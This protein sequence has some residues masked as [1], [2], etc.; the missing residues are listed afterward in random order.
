VGEQHGN[1][2]LSEP[3]L[4]ITVGEKDGQHQEDEDRIRKELTKLTKA[5]R[6]DSK[7]VSSC[8]EIKSL[9]P[10]RLL[11]ER[12]EA[13]LIECMRNVIGYR[14]DSVGRLLM[15][16]AAQ[17]EA[18]GNLLQHLTCTPRLVMS[19]LSFQ[20]VGTWWLRWLVAQEL[21]EQR[22][23]RNSGFAK[24]CEAVATHICKIMETAGV[25]MPN[26]T[27]QVAVKT[28][29]RVTYGR[30]FSDNGVL[31]EATWKM[32]KMVSGGLRATSW[33]NCDE[34]RELDLQ[35]GHLRSRLR[36]DYM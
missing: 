4:R 19:R 28:C 6:E 34:K 25:E 11:T 33:F 29:L 24:G 3:E 23:S 14:D 10:L 26:E 18:I 16:D 35:V 20:K 22:W 32:F 30:A 31:L 13:I 5:V 27:W 12:E 15:Q 17:A 21:T 36:G 1:I 8:V 7:V 2:T 9:L